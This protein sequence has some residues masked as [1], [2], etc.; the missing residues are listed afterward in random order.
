MVRSCGCEKGGRSSNDDCEWDM[1]RQND[2]HFLEFVAR[3]WAKMRENIACA[4]CARYGVLFTSFK[5][6]SL[7]ACRLCQCSRSWK[8]LLCCCRPWFVTCLWTVSAQRHPRVAELSLENTG[9]ERFSWI[10]YVGYCALQ[11][12]LHF[13]P[14]RNMSFCHFPRVSAGA[15]LL[16]QSLFLEP[17]GC[18]H[19]DWCAESHLAMD[20]FFPGFSCG[21]M[22]CLRIAFCAL[23][24]GILCPSA[25][26]NWISAVQCL[27]IRSL[28]AW[29]S[30]TRQQILF[31]HF[32][33][34]FFFEGWLPNSRFGLLQN[35][36]VIN[37]RS[38]KNCLPIVFLVRWE[39]FNVLQNTVTFHG[40]ADHFPSEL[41]CSSTAEVLSLILL[42]ALDSRF[43]RKL[44]RVFWGD[45]VL[46]RHDC[47]HWLPNLAP[48]LHTGD[49]YE[50]HNFHW[51]LCDLPLS[52]HQ[53]FL[54]EVRL[55]Q[56][57]FCTAPL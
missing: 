38:V 37:C 5:V 46:H 32:F 3:S 15:S 24:L 29:N 56:C 4:K 17:E 22:H 7:T 48:R 26:S 31:F 40:S 11:N 6:L 10:W 34:R 30:A 33:F 55:R 49:C 39:V 23:V 20:P 52:S 44:F 8:F 14:W 35:W 25:K 45:L 1:M 28:V 41:D 12:V 2:K 42:T 36:M 27:G 47:N 21:V 9:D 19:E 51:E 16:F 43:F 57:V 50:I 53:N 13:Q 54:H 18:A